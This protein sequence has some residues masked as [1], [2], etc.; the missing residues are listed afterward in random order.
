MG[1]GL[2]CPPV[3]RYPSRSDAAVAVLCPLAE[4]LGA[5][6]AEHPIGLG[7]GAVVVEHTVAVGSLGTCLEG[8][9]SQA[10][11]LGEIQQE[12]GTVPTD[13]TGALD[14]QVGDSLGVTQEGGEAGGGDDGEHR[15]RLVVGGLCRPPCPNYS[16]SGVAVEGRQPVP[17]LAL[18]GGRRCS[19]CRCRSR[20]GRGGDPGG[21]PG[22]AAPLPGGAWRML[23]SPSG[24]RGLGGQLRW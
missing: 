12:G 2:E 18:S 14:Q 17:E 20:R 8:T 22:G 7:D 21:S 9:A 6:L 24:R 1:G 11:A 15:S 5:R 3:A 10:V 4:A 16:G 13:H 19:R 23:P